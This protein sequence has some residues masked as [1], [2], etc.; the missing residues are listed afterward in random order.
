MSTDLHERGGF[1]LANAVRNLYQ[2]GQV[3]YSLEPVVQ[4]DSRGEP[5]GRIQDGDAVI[6]CCRR[7]EREIQLTDAFVDPDLDQFPRRTFHDL[8]FRDPHPVPR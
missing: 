3:D 8:D 1:A 6:F 2:E 5:V 7:G 4:V